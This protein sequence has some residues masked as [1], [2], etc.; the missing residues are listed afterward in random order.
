MKGRVLQ[1]GN[2]YDADDVNRDHSRNQTSINI[3]RRIQLR[4]HFIKTLREP[5]YQRAAPAVKVDYFATP[6]CSRRDHLGWML[7]RGV[8][9][10]GCYWIT[11][12]GEGVEI[13]H[14][15]QIS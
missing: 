4:R 8:D 12:C 10:V 9:W 7:H 11:G 14:S 13:N 1:Y 3:R 2:Y 15:N 5:L 6:A